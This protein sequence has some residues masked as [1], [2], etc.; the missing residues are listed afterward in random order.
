LETSRTVARRRTIDRSKVL[1]VAEDIV[2]RHGAAALTIDA[3]AKA[4][5][6]T[7]GGVQYCFGTKEDLVVAI[8]ERW[9]A[10][11]E[12]EVT[13]I[14]GAGA[15]WRQ[16][17]RSYVVASSRID[18]SAQSKMV[19]MLVTLLQSPEH[20]ERVRSWYSKW[21]DKFEPTSAA[22]R[23][24]RTAFFA[25]EGAFILRSLGLVQMSQTEWDGIFADLIDQFTPRD[26]DEAPEIRA[27][28]AATQQA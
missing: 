28:S 11:F 1:D 23:R 18:P 4:A 26:S 15:D 16:S 27:V 22:G 12:A 6:I 24:T 19:G 21:I 25:A 7:K 5:G 17:M 20:M 10:T 13:K 8:I 14:A 3:V 9:I 2:R